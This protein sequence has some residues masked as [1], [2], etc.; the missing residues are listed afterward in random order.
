MSIRFF[1]TSNPNI[2][3]ATQKNDLKTHQKR[4]TCGQNFDITKLMAPYQTSIC[5][6]GPPSPQPPP[7]PREPPPAPCVPM[8]NSSSIQSFNNAN[9]NTSYPTVSQP[10]PSGTTVRTPGMPSIP[11]S[12]HHDLSRMSDSVPNSPVDLMTH[13]HQF[14][15]FPGGGGDVNMIPNYPN[16]YQQP[17]VDMCNQ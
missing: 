15:P 14:V 17:K 10:L 4:N 11:P 16:H 6:R 1:F 5:V 8:L 13:R 3:N 2:T 12:P 7:P 9:T